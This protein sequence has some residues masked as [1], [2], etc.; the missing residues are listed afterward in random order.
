MANIKYSCKTEEPSE[1]NRSLPRAQDIKRGTLPQITCNGQKYYVDFRLGELRDVKT[2]KP[3]KFSELKE[4]PKSAFKK[5]L[6]TLRSLYA[7]PGYF[8]YTK[9]IDD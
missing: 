6:R 5:N 9:G 3:T 7:P 4:S 8:G 1:F 2:A